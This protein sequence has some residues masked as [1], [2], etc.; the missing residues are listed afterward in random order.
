[1][2]W[3]IIDMHE[4]RGKRQKEN[5]TNEKKKETRTIIAATISITRGQ[6]ENVKRA[7]II[8]SIWE[9]HTKRYF[10][11]FLRSF[12]N[13]RRAINT[14][15]AMQS[16]FTRTTKKRE[17][18]NEHEMSNKKIPAKG[19]NRPF[20]W[21]Q[22]TKSMWTQWKRVLNELMQ[23]V[24]ELGA[25]NEMSKGV[26]RATVSCMW[27]WKQKRLLPLFPEFWMTTI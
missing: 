23:V 18:S 24:N 15:V 9:I 22:R 3:I 7:K 19:L 6:R 13:K 8:A 25:W 11:S 20:K 14:L 1:M 5:T 27:N 4:E 2:F 10:S 17:V 16:R 21:R 12:I 26:T